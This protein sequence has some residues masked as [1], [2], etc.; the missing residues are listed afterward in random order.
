[1]VARGVLVSTPLTKC[2]SRMIFFYY[3]FLTSGQ[4]HV[5]G[6]VFILGEARG[7]WPYALSPLL[8]FFCLLYCLNMLTVAHFCV[9]KR[10]VCQIMA[11]ER[12]GIVP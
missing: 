4:V 9:D 2:P 5:L 6:D 12:R 11:E 7:I 10:V 3:F 8:P 1:M